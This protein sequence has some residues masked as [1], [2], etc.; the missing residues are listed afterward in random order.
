M[1]GLLEA[2]NIYLH[3]RGGK[4]VGLAG[5]VGVIVAIIIAIIWFDWIQPVINFFGLNKVANDM[6]IVVE[7]IGGTSATAYNVLILYLFFCLGFSLVVGI[8]LLMFVYGST[9]LQTSFGGTLVGVTLFIIFSP[10]LIWFTISK[11]IELNKEG[12][13]ASVNSVSKASVSNND[14]QRVSKYKGLMDY[15]VRTTEKDG[16]TNKV[17]KRDAVHYLHQ[18]PSE[19]ENRFLIGITND[20]EP[21]LLFPRPF[22]TVVFGTVH[23]LLGVPL[24]FE[25][26]IPMKHDP[27][28]VGG[29]SNPHRYYMRY[30]EELKQWEMSE[31]EVFIYPKEIH[32]VQ[33][34]LKDFSKDKVYSN[35]VSKI[36]EHYNM[37]KGKKIELEEHEKEIISVVSPI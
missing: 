10:I 28:G 29:H 24:I 32:D 16:K 26:F 1:N 22:G 19:E 12:K 18:I 15:L 20:K 31:I 35:Y 34:V 9:A 30:G 7:G 27:H 11:I 36:H 25:E 14:K 17:R 6:G 5:L 4:H 37:N 23:R 33:R 3:Y 13:K 21:V 8:G 2:A